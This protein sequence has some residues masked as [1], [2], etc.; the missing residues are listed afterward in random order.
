MKIFILKQGGT[1]LIVPPCIIEIAE[2]K[3]AVRELTY[4]QYILY[5]HI[6]Q[7]ICIYVYY[8][9]YIYTVYTRNKTA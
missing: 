1:G 9:Y 6:I 5:M 3:V 8:I 2:P 4:I 7:Y